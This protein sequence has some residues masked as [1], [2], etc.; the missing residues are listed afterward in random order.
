[1][2]TVLN[3]KKCNIQTDTHAQGYCHI[4]YKK[5]RR[6]GG[7]NK[8]YNSPT[9]LNSLQQNVLI[10]SLLG[11]GCL[12]ISGTTDRSNAN[13][14]IQ[15]KL[16]DKDYLEWEFRI[17][18]NF[19][20]KDSSTI[21]KTFDK[22]TNKYYNFVRFETLCSPILTT[23][24]KKWYKNKIK[25]IPNDLELNN[26]IMMIWFCDD[27]N[28]HIENKPY[29][30]LITFATNCFTRDEVY[31]LKDKLSDRYNEKFRVSKVS[32]KEQYILGAANDASRAI[33]KDIDPLINGFMN[34]KSIVW[35]NKEARFYENIP[36]HHSVERKIIDFILQNKEFKL[37]ELASHLELIKDNHP[38][39]CVFRKYIDKYIKKNILQEI[40][41]NKKSN[42]YILGFNGEEELKKIFKEL[43]K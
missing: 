13:L 10:G 37:R 42:R 38:I 6:Y 36:K 33:L 30:F 22:R 32:H 40:Q 26:V 23:F 16:E 29:T 9:E 25:I 5:Q 34:R 15:R 19:I 24:Y 31:F 43:I 18:K 12:D 3:C 11:D 4:C 1:M 2:K 41:I 17:F 27:G 7:L 35:R 39:Y 14:T 21:G 20:S 8:L 28:L